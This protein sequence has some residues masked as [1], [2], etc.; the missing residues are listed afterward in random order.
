VFSAVAR[1]A[2]KMIEK[3]GGDSTTLKSMG[4]HPETHILGETFYTQVPLLHGPYMAK[5]SVVPISPGMLLLKDAPL[6][7]HD[8]PDGL[9][10]AVVDFFSTHSAEWELRVQLCTDIQAMPIEDASAVWSEE[11]SPYLP[12][13][14]IT[15]APQQAWSEARAAAIDS[16]Y[17]FSPWHGL[18]A[19][20]PLGSIMRVRKAAYEMSASFRATHSGQRIQEPKSL[21]SLPD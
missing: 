17:S 13:A 11:L 4:G 5:L 9:R 20:R 18:A 7:L 12:V 8:K 2:E 19:H 21:E 3:V 6:D 15:V 16:S 14:R 1:G 10:D